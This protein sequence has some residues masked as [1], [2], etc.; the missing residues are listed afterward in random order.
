MKKILVG[1]DGSEPSAHALD[2][3]CLLARAYGSPLTILTSADD[4]LVR[5]DGHMT[6][7]ADEG[8]ARWTAEQ[9]AQRARAAGVGDVSV[10][11]SIEAPVEGLVHAAKA[12]GFDLLVVGHRGLSALKEWFLGST[13]KS[14]VDRVECSVLIVR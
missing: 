11:V 4:R 9:G 5:E 3:A 1:Y 8:L 10:Q 13:A 7:A 14:V 6:M 12:G 2:Q